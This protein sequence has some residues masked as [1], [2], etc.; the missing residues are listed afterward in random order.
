MNK[1]EMDRNEIIEIIRYG[2]FGLLS[3]AINL[4]LFVLFNKLGIYYIY[5]NTIAYIIAVI[6]NYI[7]NYMF[8]FTEAE[9]KWKWNEFLKFAIVKIVALIIDNGLF[10]I[11]VSIMHINI[12]ISR[13]SLSAVIIIITYIINKKM[14][15]GARNERI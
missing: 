11:M 9:K 5:A 3:T 2:L 7:F 1:I 10:Y 12:Y 15:F 8:V 6:L 13:I 14:V 4:G